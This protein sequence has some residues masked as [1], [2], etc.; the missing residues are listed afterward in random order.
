MMN[1]KL[2]L[3]H[4]T[5]TS[6]YICPWCYL[7]ISRLDRIVKELSDQ[8]N[9]I[10]IHEPYQLYPLTPDEGTPKE[11]FAKK[12]KKGMGKALR[13]EAEIEGIEIN[14]KNIQRVPNT[15]E[16]HRWTYL[17]NDLSLRWRFSLEVFR[18]YFEIGL[19][20]GD[21][22]VLQ[23]VAENIGIDPIDVAAHSDPNL[24]V[25][26][27]NQEIAKAKE[28]FITVVP[29]INIDNKLTMSGLQEDRLWK[30]FLLKAAKMAQ[31]T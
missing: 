29:T 27:V 2:P 22:T 24:G 12:T 11:A 14:Y 21:A 5:L 8:V 6:D 17:I 19:D 18:A 7:G 15:L 4:I 9:I 16:A 13:A 1:N 20:I 26:Y 25:Q 10:A 30:K 28:N 3:V 23:Q 31:K